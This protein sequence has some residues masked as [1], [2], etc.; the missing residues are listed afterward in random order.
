MELKLLD[1]TQDILDLILD[2]TGKPVEFIM[3]PGMQ[4]LAAVKIARESMP[5]HIIYYKDSKSGIMNHLVAHE[6]GHI[7]RMMSVPTEY[8]KVP[9]TTSANKRIA[10]ELLENDLMKLSKT[11]PVEQFTNMWFEGIVTQVTNVA[12]DMRIEKWIFDNYPKLQKVQK[13]SI[14]KQMKENVQ[15]LSDRIKNMTP[16]HIYD[17]NSYM[18]YAFAYFMGSLL[19]KNYIAPYKRTPYI[20]LGTK[21]AD[22]VIGT[23]DHGY[24]QDIEIIDK[25]VNMLDL[26]GWF[27]WTDFETIPSDY[28]EQW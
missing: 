6:C 23:E 10:M 27:F 18:N 5:S 7:H 22:I 17:A 12:V 9:A 28:L 25:W 26:N 1:T 4:T 19:S 16:K 24:K 8:R 11:I 20:E 15:A 14:D 2:L 21:L 3:K 13:T